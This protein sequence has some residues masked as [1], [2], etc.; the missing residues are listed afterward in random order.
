[1]NVSNI[2]PLIA[3]LNSKERSV[4]TKIEITVPAEVVWL[5]P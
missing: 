3:K 4:Q 1:M 2:K 5:V